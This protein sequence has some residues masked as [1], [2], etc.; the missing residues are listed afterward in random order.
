MP[1]ITLITKINSDIHVVFDLARSIDLHQLTAQHTNER[2]IA[3]TTSGLIGMDETVTWEARHFGIKMQLCSKITAFSAPHHFRDEQVWG[4][5]SYIW[6]DHHFLQKGDQ[7]LMTDDFRLGAPLGPLGR[8]AEKLVLEPYLRRFL[9][10]RNGLLKTIA[11]SN[12]WRRYT[13]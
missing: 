5:F 9:H 1:A 2:A 11:E 13:D 4:P 6:H 7:V 3:G 10:H 12:D 8:I